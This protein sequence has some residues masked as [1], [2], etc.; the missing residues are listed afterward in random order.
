MRCEQNQ[1]ES[2]IRVGAKTNQH[3]TN[4]KHIRICPTNGPKIVHVQIY[5]KNWTHYWK[6]P[7]NE[8][9]FVC[10]QKIDK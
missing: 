10:V 9:I 1:D 8:R 2:I 3:D 7:K 4:F 6:C 5:C